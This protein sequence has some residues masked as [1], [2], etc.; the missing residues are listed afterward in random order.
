[1]AEVLDAA[2]DT[3]LLELHTALPGRIESYDGSTQKANIKPL[4]K[5]AYT[6]EEDT[7]RVA[8]IPVIPSVPVL[9]PGGGGYRVTFPVAAGDFCL[10]VVS[11]SSMDRWLSGSGGEVDPEID[12][13]H[14]LQDAVAIVGIKP[15]G[16]PWSSAPTD[17]AT[18]GKDDGVQI[19]MESGTITIGDKAGS[20]FI[21]LA[22]KVATELAA[23][24]A[25]FTAWTPVPN[26]GG[27]VLKNLLTA[28]QAGP[29]AWPGSVAATQAKAK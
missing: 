29:P 1:M 27:L 20:E 15:F 4:V 13:H 23:L 5:Q 12:Q 28:L 16:A 6:D 9:F 17:E 14:A 21:A 18:I 25:V 7:R 19:H 2:I 24:S 22:S 26:D 11:E 10:L 3:R 8:S